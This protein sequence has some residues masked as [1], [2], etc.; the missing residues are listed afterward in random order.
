MEEIFTKILKDTNQAKYP[1]VHKLCFDAQALLTNQLELTRATPYHLRDVCLSA[2]QEALESKNSKIILHSIKGFEEIVRDKSFQASFETEDEEKW[3]PSQLVKAVQSVSSQQDEVQLEILKILLKMAYGSGWYLS[4]L[5]VLQLLQLYCDVYI[6]GSGQVKTASLATASQTLQAFCSF[7]QDVDSTDQGNTSDDSDTE[8]MNASDIMDDILPV[9]KFLCDHLKNSLNQEKVVAPLM[10]ECFLCVLCHLQDNVRNKKAFVN[11]VWQD[12][13]P[14]LVAI[15]G[16]PKTDKKNIT[17]QTNTLGENKGEMGRGSG[18]LNAAPSCLSANAKTIYSLSAELVRLFGSVG[19][20]RPV[21]ASLFHRMLLYPPAQHRLEALKALKEKFLS[22]PELLVQLSAPPLYDVNNKNSR[23]SDLDLLKI[24]MDS[25]SQCSHSQDSA[26]CCSAVSCILSLLNSLEI[27]ME[28][29]EMS[30]SHIS[31]INTIYTFLDDAEITPHIVKPLDKMSIKEEMDNDSLEDSSKITPEFNILTDNESQPIP[32]EGDSLSIQDNFSDIE[33]EASDSLE[34]K[35]S[36]PGVE[37]ENKNKK[38][39]EKVDVNNDENS[40]ISKEK[41]DCVQSENEDKLN[42]EKNVLDKKEL[43]VKINEDQLSLS[44]GTTEG[45]E[46]GEE[47]DFD[48]L[49]KELEEQEKQ[50]DLEETARREKAPRTLLGEEDRGKEERERVEKLCEAY[51]EFAQIERQN[52]QHFLEVLIDLLPSVLVVKSSIEADQA[53]QEFASKYCEGMWKK[54]DLQKPRNDETNLRPVT[55]VNADGIYLATFSTLLLNLKLVKSGYYEGKAVKKLMTEHEFIEGVHGSGVLVYLSATWLSEVYQ[56]IMAKNVLQ[57]A[58]YSP[59]DNRNH[60][61]INLLVDLDGLGS[62]EQGG[63]LLSDYKRLERAVSNIH[64]SPAREAGMKFTRLVLTSFWDIVLD[65]P[66][67]LL[68]GTNECGITDNLGLILGTE[69]AKEDNRRIKEAVAESLD[70]LQIAARLCNLLGLQSS[71][72]AVFEQ[73]AVASCPLNQESSFIGNAN[74]KRPKL[75][76]KKSVL[77]NWTKC[78]RL[79]PSHIL[80][81]DVILK[82]GLELGSHSPHCWKHVFR[83]TLYVMGL[84]HAFFSAHGKSTMLPIVNNPTRKSTTSKLEKADPNGFYLPPYPSNEI[85]DGPPLDLSF[86]PGR[87]NPQA[88]EIGSLLKQTNESG[89]IIKDKQLQ[90]IVEALSQLVDTL[91]EEASNQL[92]LSALITFL[93]ELC[94]ASQEQLFTQNG[95]YLKGNQ[96]GGLQNYARTPHTNSLLMNRLADVMLHTAR[97]GRP[98]IHVMKAWSVVAPHFV[99]AACHKEQDIS[100]QAVTS[101]HDIVSALLCSNPELPHF[102]FNESLFKPFENLL[103]LELCDLDVQEQII[104]SICEFVESCTAEVRSGWRPLFG[105]LRAVRLSDPSQIKGRSTLSIDADREQARYLRV[106]LDVFNA[107]LGTENTLVFANAAVDCLLCLLKH[108]RGPTELQDNQNL[109]PNEPTNINESMPLDLCLAALKYLER[110]SGILSFM[111]KM[112]ACPVLNSANRIQVRREYILVDPVIQNIDFQFLD[113]NESHWVKESAAGNLCLANN[114]SLQ[115]NVTL[116]S[117]DQPTGILHV[118]FLLFEGL[119]GAVSTCPRKYQPHTMETLFSMLNSLKYTPGPNFGIICVNHLLLPM[120]Q[121]WL[122]RTARIYRGWDNYATNFKQCCGLTTDLVVD[123]LVH[124]SDNALLNETKGANVMFYQL[125]LVLTECVAQAVESVSRLGCACIRHVL[126]SAGHVLTPDQW[127][128]A[129]SCLVRASHVSLRSVQQLMACFRTDSENVYG[130]VGQVKVAARKDCTPLE[131]ERL[132]Q[133]AQQVLLLDCQSANGWVERKNNACS[134]KS[135]VFLLHPPGIE[136]TSNPDLFIVRV[137]FRS[138]V[139]G[140]VS[141]QVLLQ[142]LATILLQGTRYTLPSLSSLL[143]NSIPLS[144]SVHTDLEPVVSALP[145]F[146]SHLNS[147]NLQRILGCLSESYETAVDFDWRPGLK[148]L[149]QKV[150]QAEVAANLYKQAGISW[151]IQALVLFELCLH[152]PD[153][154]LG[155]VNHQLDR[156]LPKEVEEECDSCDSLEGNEDEE[157][158]KVGKEALNDAEEVVENQDAN[159]F[160]RLRTLFTD[161]CN[162]YADVVLDKEGTSIVDRIADE[163]IFFL[164]LQPDEFADYRKSVASLGEEDLAPSAFRRS[165]VDSSDSDEPQFDEGPDK[166]YSVATEK[167]INNVVSEYKKRKTRHSMPSS[168]KERPPKKQSSSESSSQQ[169]FIPEDVEKQRRNSILKDSEARQQVSTQ[170]LQSV[171]DLH[172]SLPDASFHAMLPV[173]FPGVQVLVVYSVDNGLRTTIADWMGRMANCCGFG[174]LTTQM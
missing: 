9:L 52:A 116:E 42:D 167:T 91:F 126:T 63:Q 37:I 10:L 115:T 130:D 64:C 112:P 108:V 27:I 95:S 17:S 58:G 82:R 127:E 152:Q 138:V 169:S 142:T 7:L 12:F 164:T 119:V 159:P 147:T 136:N 70:A 102:H 103:C 31:L 153:L 28:G 148:F 139:V 39:E 13:C 156:Q 77:N 171:L 22:K 135:F 155:L 23:C 6:N 50:K 35:Y 132:H 149:M 83:C 124:L 96:G 60:A 54:Q 57:I 168:F 143:A 67:L 123:Y 66:S 174:N 55:I 120:L 71:C 14:I 20:F 33:E 98:L 3:L 133:L 79:H 61:L 16:S 56:Q 145:G 81:L 45:P 104:S 122:R 114:A 173:I 59:V 151:T 101:I 154:S 46:E 160:S 19:S 161:I 38:N 5:G 163:P 172:L 49:D 113:C 41:L 106:V 51:D 76:L 146:L 78:I 105:A 137:P 85:E 29:K 131:F 43:S 125:L 170:L 36:D 141:H 32:L 68:N 74:Q 117:L 100:K 80:S 75:R 4:T 72:G 110:C 24:I 34:R 157:K 140:L 134:D 65:I 118:W 121:N 53:L 86:I 26:V 21:L 97:G 15:L 166:V 73:L 25:L 84:E 109:I 150:A 90:P 162:S 93:A 30:D 92:N 128:I 99:E 87:G 62:S 111:Y 8:T 11:F 69:G 48:N 129:C 89:G 144:P 44:S 165:S 2:L 1:K 94:A 107:F 88:V 158:V 40:E 47:K 18:C